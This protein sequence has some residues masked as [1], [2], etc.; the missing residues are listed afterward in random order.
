V[1]LRWFILF[2]PLEHGLNEGK[3]QQIQGVTMIPILE[4]FDVFRIVARRLS[5]ATY[6]RLPLKWS[7]TYFNNV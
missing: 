1:D 2:E 7:V 4:H 3:A 6:I 5:L